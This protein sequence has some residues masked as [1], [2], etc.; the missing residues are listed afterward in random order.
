MGL[1]KKL[2]VGFLLLVLIGVAG[3]YGAQYYY[4]HAYDRVL[5]EGK[6]ETV[7]GD[8]FYLSHTLSPGKY[9]VVARSEGTVER[10]AILDT[11]GNV[12]TE[13]EGDSLFYTTNRPFQV[14]IDYKASGTGKYRVEAEIYRLVERG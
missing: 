4:L 3:I 13:S 2:F 10:I 7:S 9:Y 11:D 1:L 8:V 12:L 14:R 5:V 6:S